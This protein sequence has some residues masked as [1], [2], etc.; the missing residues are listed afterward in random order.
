MDNI[1]KTNVQNFFDAT[2][3]PLQDSQ[4]FVNYPK[5]SLINNIEKT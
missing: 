1:E 5:R 2:E 3:T 4:P